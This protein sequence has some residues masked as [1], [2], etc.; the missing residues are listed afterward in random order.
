M[1]ASILLCVSCCYCCEKGELRAVK[2]TQCASVGTLLSES[3][4]EDDEASGR[5]N[6]DIRTQV[7]EGGEAFCGE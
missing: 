4:G 2:A 3:S 6:S 1:I 7:E 5:G